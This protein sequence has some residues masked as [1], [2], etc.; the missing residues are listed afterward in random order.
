MLSAA[1]S[2]VYP[3]ARGR[4]S[5]PAA[6]ARRDPH[7]A[8]LRERRRLPRGARDADSGRASRSSARRRGPGSRARGSSSRSSSGQ[9][10]VAER[11]ASRFKTT[12]S[13]GRG[14]RRSGSRG[15]TRARRLWSTRPSPCAN[16]VARPRARTSPSRPTAADKSPPPPEGSPRRRRPRRHR[17]PTLSL[18]SAPPST[19]ERSPPPA[20]VEPTARAPSPDAPGR[21]SLLERLRARARALYPSDIERILAERRRA[22]ALRRLGAAR[23]SSSFGAGNPPLMGS[24]A[25]P[26]IPA[27]ETSGRPSGPR[28][29]QP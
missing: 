27:G 5:G 14:G 2:T 22:E 4:R 7:H 8:P 24:R 13:Q 16:S 11:D 29:V 9:V 6:S 15:S 26:T 21:D 23:R 17:R 28:K 1:C 12:R 20:Q 3:C 10:L 18:G 25:E 19:V